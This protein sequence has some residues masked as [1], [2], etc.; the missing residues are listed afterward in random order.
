VTLSS[1][2]ARGTTFGGCVG[3]IVSGMRD[4]PQNARTEDLNKVVN[5]PSARRAPA[6]D[7]MPSS[8]RLGPATLAGTSRNDTGKATPC[9]VR[10]VLPAV[11]T[12]QAQ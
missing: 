7:P 3:K 10:Q 12:K 8:R 2:T 1:G 11:D 6:A 5:T 4:N 9:Q